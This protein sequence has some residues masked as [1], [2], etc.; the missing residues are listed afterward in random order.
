MS[1][2]NNPSGQRPDIF[3]QYA[4]SKRDFST[5]VPDESIDFVDSK[6]RTNIE[7]GSL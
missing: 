7:R 5:Q 6:I 4:A 2:A 1:K 3:A